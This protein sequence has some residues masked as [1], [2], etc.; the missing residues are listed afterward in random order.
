MK[1]LDIGIEIHIGDVMMGK[2]GASSSLRR[3]IIGDAVNC[4]SRI[5]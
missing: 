1:S 4:A 5:E 2:I 3:M